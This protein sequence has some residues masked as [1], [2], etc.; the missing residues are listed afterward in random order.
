MNLKLEKQ[1]VQQAI[2]QEKTK[3]A[4][5]KVTSKVKS[6]LLGWL[7]VGGLISGVFSGIMKIVKGFAEKFDKIGKSFGT[8][9]SDK[10]F[11]QNLLDAEFSAIALGKSLEDVITSV[12]TLSENFGYNLDAATA[13]QKCQY[14]ICDGK[15][16]GINTDD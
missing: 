12:S 9:A 11:T 13:P 4:M 1:L 16:T 6:S 2:K 3:R 15:D 5:S 14:L 7:S 10:Q 8:L